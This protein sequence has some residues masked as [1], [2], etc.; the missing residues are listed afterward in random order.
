MMAV[1]LTFIDAIVKLDQL[2][3]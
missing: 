1:L 2:L 3:I